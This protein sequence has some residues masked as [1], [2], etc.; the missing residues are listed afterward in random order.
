MQPLRVDRLGKV[1]EAQRGGGIPKEIA[2]MLE[3]RLPVLEEA[4]E[5]VEAASGTVYPPYYIM[6]LLILVRSEAEVGETGVYYA[7]NV[8]VVVAGRL[9]LLI[10]FT[11]PLLLHASKQT[12]QAVAAHEFTHYLEL[13]RRFSTAPSSSP[14]PST[15]FEATYK[16]MQEAF[17]AEKVFGRYRSLLTAMNRKFVEGFVDEP[18]NRRVVRSWLGKKLP[19]VAVRPDD[20]AVKIPVTAITNA[21]LDTAALARISSLQTDGRRPA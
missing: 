13:I 20:N 21:N 15:M 3:S 2:D 14:S 11:A 7:R 5:K 9:N 19:C 6:P 10:E 4:V 17:P 8:P 16:D 18:L 1:H 12:L